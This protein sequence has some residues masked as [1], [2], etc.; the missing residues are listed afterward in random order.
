MEKCIT[1]HHVANIIKIS[2]FRSTLKNIKNCIETANETKHSYYGNIKINDIAP[3]FFS[4]NYK[5]D[6]VFPFKTLFVI[7][8]VV[9]ITI[10]SFCMNVFY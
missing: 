10:H 7:Y 5:Q 1:S 2:V 3:F 6:A 8:V 9:P 4:T